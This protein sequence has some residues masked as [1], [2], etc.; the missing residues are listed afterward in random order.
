MFLIVL[1]RQLGECISSS[2]FP[3]KMGTSQLKKAWMLD[4]VTKMMEL[5]LMLRKHEMILYLSHHM[6]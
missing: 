5:R 3:P 2:F 4:F 1:L 6:V